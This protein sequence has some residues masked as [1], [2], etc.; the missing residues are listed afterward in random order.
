MSFEIIM[1]EH[2]KIWKVCVLSY[3]AGS[4]YGTTAPKCANYLAFDADLIPVKSEYGH[5]HILWLRSKV[6]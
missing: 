6:R 1:G 3:N 4:F 5:K 2:K